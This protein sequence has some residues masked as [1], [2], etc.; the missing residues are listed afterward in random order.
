MGFLVAQMVKNPQQCGRPEF[1]SWLGKIPWRR[2]WQPIP[3]FLPGESHRQRSLEDYSPQGCKESGTD[4]AHSTRSFYHIAEVENHRFWG[5]DSQLASHNVTCL[6]Y[7]QEFPGGPVRLGLHASIAGGTGLISGWGTN[8]PQ[9][10]GHGQKKKDYF[11]L[12]P[13]KGKMK[14]EKWSF[15][16]S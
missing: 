7:F 11:L 5:Q 8:N 16:H 9:G 2:A 3:V 15:S 10:M 1:D 4:L 13:E 6:R 14:L 12:F